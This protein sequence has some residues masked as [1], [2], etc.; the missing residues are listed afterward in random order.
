ML[1]YW[2]ASRRQVKGLVSITRERRWKKMLYVRL[3][4]TGCDG[5]Y[6]ELPVSLSLHIAAVVILVFLLQR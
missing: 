6:L 3:V 5:H 2:A 4:K 1:E